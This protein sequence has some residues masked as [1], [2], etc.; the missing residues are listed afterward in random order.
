MAKKGQSILPNAAARAVQFIKNKNN[1][2]L[3]SRKGG[4]CMNSRLAI[5]IG[6]VWLVLAVII[7]GIVLAKPSRQV[8]HKNA[9]Y[10][11]LNAPAYVPPVDKNSPMGDAAKI[12]VRVDGTSEDT[13]DIKVN[14]QPK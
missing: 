7:A 9:M 2:D 14:V 1:Y 3:F 10:P 5:T 8:R 4:D 12:K 13:S 11:P 6:A